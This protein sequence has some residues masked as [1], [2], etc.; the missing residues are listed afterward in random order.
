MSN[1]D[2]NET[3]IHRGRDQRVLRVSDPAA[4]P[5]L[6]KQGCP[7][8]DLDAARSALHNPVYHR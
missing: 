1:P 6:V 3:E 2:A 5:L 4:G 8:G 7:D